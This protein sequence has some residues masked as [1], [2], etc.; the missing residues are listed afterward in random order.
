MGSC[1]TPRTT[2]TTLTAFK[3][4]IAFT[5]LPKTFQDAVIFTRRLQIRYLWIDS[6]CIIQEDVDDW[7]KQAPQMCSIYHG[8]ALTLAASGA[9]DSQ[10]GLF[11]PAFLDHKDYTIQDMGINGPCNIHLRHPIKHLDFISKWGDIAEPHLP[12]L[13]RGWV[14]QERLLSPRVLQFCREEL[15]FECTEETSCECSGIQKATRDRFVV[16]PKF[17]HVKVLE[18]VLELGL[19]KIGGV[20]YASIVT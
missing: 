10:G 15:I 8:S 20:W 1:H 5:S 18:R 2:K 4:G 6:L 16:R 9:P 7:H 13:K 3:N 19:S 17:S 11:S 12:L 14:Y